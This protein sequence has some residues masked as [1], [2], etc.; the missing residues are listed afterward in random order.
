VIVPAGGGRVFGYTRVSSDGQADNTS[1][2]V[3]AER[4]AAFALAKGMSTPELFSDVASGANT[5]RPGLAAL[6]AAVAPGDTVI[7]F[8]LDRLGRSIV[9]IEPLISGWERRNVSVYSVTEPIETST[10]MGRTMFRVVLVFAQGEREVIAE[11]V[12]SGKAKTARDG[13]F[14]GSPIPFGYRR[15]PGSDA[16]V[17]DP[18][19]ARMVRRLFS[20]FASGRYGI[21]RLRAATGCPLSES[22]IEKLLSNPT[23]TGRHPYGDRARPAGHER[24]VSDR[25]FG[26]V[27]RERARRAR[28]GQVRLW[29]ASEIEGEMALSVWPTL[30]RG[31]HPGAV[32]GPPLPSSRCPLVTSFPMAPPWS[33]PSPL[34]PFGV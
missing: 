9:D 18:D 34:D 6:R 16:F 29:K 11:R 10:A 4:I 27:Q 17:V 20:M 28:S 32:S 8:K 26:R 5:N 14:N 24:L 21:G 13:K 7:V 3:Q 12:A 15:E 22:G 25:L 23:Y 2:A 19:A 1:L 33:P 31:A 30:K